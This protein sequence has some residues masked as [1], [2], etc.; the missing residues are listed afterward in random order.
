[1]KRVW[2]GLTSTRSVKDAP[3]EAS[4]GPAKNRTKP[5]SHGERK[6]SPHMLSL[7]ASEVPRGLQVL[8]RCAR[9]R[10]GLAT[11]VAQ[12]T[13]VEDVLERVSEVLRF[14]VDIQ[15]CCGV[16]QRLEVSR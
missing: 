13:P 9:V 14:D 7:R 15:A 2:P 16:Y 12:L 4:I 10:T 11:A 5:M 6:S 3:S 1:M 8:S